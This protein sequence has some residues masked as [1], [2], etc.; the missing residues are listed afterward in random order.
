MGLKHIMVYVD[1]GCE[2][3]LQ[4]AAD[5]AKKHDA[6][7]TACH[8]LVPLEPMTYAADTM[9]IDL[10]ATHNQL[11]SEKAARWQ[12]LVEQ[13]ARENDVAIHWR[14]LDGRLVDTIRSEL[15]YYDLLVTS[16]DI[17]GVFL[18]ILGGA[19]IATGCPTLVIP[20]GWEGAEI[21]QN[22]LVAWKPEVTANRATFAALPLLKAASSVEVISCQRHLGDKSQEQAIDRL[23]QRLAL[24]GVNATAHIVPKTVAYTSESIR[25][26]FEDSN[27]DLLVM[28]CYGHRR[29]HEWIFGGVTKD[30]LM[31]LKQ[32]LLLTH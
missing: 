23:Q 10:A 26:Y 29:V 19:L 30:L 15:L 27:A 2:I 3:S 17:H 21:G 8:I 9:F 31:E 6:I 18:P 14:Q 5:L 24:H 12:K 11:M 22:I 7:L 25:L 13:A 32:P 16:P 1:D 20:Q 28:G 4:L